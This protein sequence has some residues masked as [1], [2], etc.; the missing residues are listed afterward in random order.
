MSGALTPSRSV[1]ELLASQLPATTTSC[2]NGGNAQPQLG[3][4]R[5]DNWFKDGQPWGN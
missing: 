5:W 3:W 4:G 1:E 2:A